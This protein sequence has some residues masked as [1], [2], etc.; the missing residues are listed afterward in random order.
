M[1]GQIDE[2]FNRS[3]SS[4]VTRPSTRIASTLAPQH[5]GEK[6][7]GCAKKMYTPP[8]T[9]LLS[10]HIFPSNSTVGCHVHNTYILCTIRIDV[11]RR[12]KNGSQDGARAVCVN[13]RDSDYA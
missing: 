2:Y 13:T 10:Y 11:H 1:T 9:L 7:A 12:L 3:F 4:R 5:S 6:K 8:I